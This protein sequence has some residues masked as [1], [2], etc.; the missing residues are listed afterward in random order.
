LRISLFIGAASRQLNRPLD[1]CVGEPLR[2]SQLQA[3]AGDRDA[4]M[5]ALRAHVYS[6]S[7]RLPGS[8]DR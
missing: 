6:L 2:Y 8:N 7:S 5:D 4:L 1:I 3:M